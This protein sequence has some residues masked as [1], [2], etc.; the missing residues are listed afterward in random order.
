M[1]MST[2]IKL[3]QI[4]IL[5]GTFGKIPYSL[6]I[7]SIL[8]PFSKNERE[9]IISHCYKEKNTKNRSEQEQTSLDQS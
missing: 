2:E 1:M 6:S 5:T 3:S 7:K 4:Q 9:R 8:W